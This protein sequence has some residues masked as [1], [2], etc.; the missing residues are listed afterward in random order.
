M[1]ACERT[2]STRHSGVTEIVL[3]HAAD[4]ALQP[5]KNGGGTT[6]EVAAFP[7]GSAMDNFDWR[8]SIAEV[9][10]AGPF[11]CFEWVDRVLAV[12]AGE[13]VLTVANMQPLT[14]APGDTPYAFPGD[15]PAYG[16]LR[17]G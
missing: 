10:Q 12:I 9:R 8:V 7:P 13:L 1:R 16:A 2:R 14:M 11:S 5:W 15:V 3:L 4:R 17:G 6:Q